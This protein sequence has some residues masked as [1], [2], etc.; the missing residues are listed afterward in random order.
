MPSLLTS[1]PMLISSLQTL[2]KGKVFS[3]IGEGITTGMAAFKDSGKILGAF[4]AGFAK[5]GTLLGPFILKIG[6]AAG[7]V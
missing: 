2:S 1:I 3:S 4:G 5:I 6:L 7:A